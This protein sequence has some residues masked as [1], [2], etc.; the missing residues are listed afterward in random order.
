METL[1]LLEKELV[2]RNTVLA[3][4]MVAAVHRAGDN[5]YYEWVIENCDSA[6][7][8]Q[9]WTNGEPMTESEITDLA[10]ASVL[11]QIAES[12]QEGKFLRLEPW[13]EERLEVYGEV[14]RVFDDLGL[15]LNWDMVGAHL[16]KKTTGAFFGLD[17]VDNPIAKVAVDLWKER[18]RSGGVLNYFA[19]KYGDYSNPGSWLYEVFQDLKAIHLSTIE[20]AASVQSY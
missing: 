19:T 4:Y 5:G 1:D 17:T 10:C 3:A 12:Y 7:R 8:T 6:N 15:F 16:A 11:C 13:V 20:S 9:V 18:A 14:V 2:D